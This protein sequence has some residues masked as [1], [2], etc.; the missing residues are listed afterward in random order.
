MTT[1]TFYSYKGGVGRSLAVANVAKYLCRFGQKVFAVDF[2][3][4][5]PGLH[6]K[7]ALDQ[8]TG[9]SRIN[10]GV[11]DYVHSAA[12]GEGLPDSLSDYVI[13]VT[14]PEQSPG[15]IWLM[16]AG[17]APSGAYWRRLARLSWHD[18]FYSESAPGVPLFLELKERIQQQFEPD[19]LLIDARTGITEVGGVATTLLPDKLVCLLMRNRENLDGAREVLRSIKNAPRLPGQAEIEI[20]PVLTRIPEMPQSVS[21]EQIV[22]DIRGF[23]N[24][25]APDLSMTLNIEEVFL[26]HSERDLELSEAIRIG[27]TMS[28]D[29]SPLLRDYLRLFSRLIPKQVVDPY[30]GPLVHEAL[31]KSFDD[32]AAAEKDL[33]ALSDYTGHP[34]TYKALLKLYRLKGD[35]VQVLRTAES[36]WQVGVGVVDPTCWKMVR[37]YFPKQSKRHRQDSERKDKQPP[38][39]RDCI[40]AIWRSDGAHDVEVGLELA[41]SYRTAKDLA[42]ASRVCRE[43]FDNGERQEAVVVPYLESLIR[44]DDFGGAL[45]VIETVK[46]T[47]NKSVDFLR[48]WATVLLRIGDP[49]VIADFI[50]SKDPGADFLKERGYEAYLELLVKVNRPSEVEK[51]LGE[52]LADA[53]RQGGPSQSLFELGRLFDRHGLWRRFDDGVRSAFSREDAEEFLKHYDARGRYRLR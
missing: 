28:A 19:F 22:A 53:L 48:A 13:P 37:E 12:T 24:E 7:F 18:L 23:L 2:D 21:E 43:L 41:E 42:K 44:T 52:H 33:R 14:G 20:V 8:E 35:G 10:K 30:V 40:A 9:V 32:P 15:R 26:L 45:T 5:A 47:L 3:L 36:L 46:R 34:D 38:F 29:E 25:E 16:P 49:A 31:M 39:N 4:E 11:V 51:L 50:D 17:D 27:G 1:I 6:Y